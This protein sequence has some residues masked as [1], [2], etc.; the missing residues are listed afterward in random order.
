MTT[1]TMAVGLP[2]SGKSTY[3]GHLSQFENIVRVSSD[4]IRDRYFKDINDQTHNWEV[5]QI[6][7]KETIKLL[8]AGENVYFDATNINRKKRMS[9]LKNLKQATRSLDIHWKVIIFAVPADV[10]V[11]RQEKRNRKVPQDV[12]HRMMKNFNVPAYFEGWNEII[13]LPLTE[14]RFDAEEYLMETVDLPHDNPRHE[15][16]VG[17]HM[18]CADKKMIDLLGRPAVITRS[19][20][21]LLAAARYHD[22]G[23]PLCKNVDEKTGIAHYYNHD[24]VGGYMILC[25]LKDYKGHKMTC[26]DIRK[27]ALLVEYHMVSFNPGYTD[28]IKKLPS[29]FVDAIETL[30]SADLAA[31]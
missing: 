23:K 12:I 29:P 3:Y 15:L 8:K 1:F 16:S 18:I 2:G 27:V 4:E 26:E 25:H 20:Y 28:I 10:C 14:R 6:A 13:T 7:I 17:E 9:L 31:H 5:F 22:I 21:I 19:D 24:K 11:E 30:H